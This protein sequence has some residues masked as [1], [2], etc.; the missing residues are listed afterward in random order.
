MNKDLIVLVNLK[1]GVSPEDYER[2]VCDS[3]APVAKA[4]P[5]VQD[6]RGYRVDGLLASDVLPPHQ[7][8]VI[9]EVNDM[10]QL[11]RDVAGEDMQRLLSELPRFAEVTQLSSQRFV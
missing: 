9:V 2:W 4:L 10:E 6:W 3:Y 1:E 5:S 8:V 11:G 7:Y